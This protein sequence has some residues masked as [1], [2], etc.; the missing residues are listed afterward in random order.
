VL[1]VRSKIKTLKI[2]FGMLKAWHS[3]VAVE[4][5]ETTEME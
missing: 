4:I 3:N 5:K 2:A 1:G